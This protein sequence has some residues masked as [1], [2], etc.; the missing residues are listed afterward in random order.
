MMDDLNRDGEIDV[1][2]ATVLYQIVDD[3]Y[4]TP[5]YERF[6]GG[7]GRYEAT[8]AHGPFVHVDARGFRARW[9]K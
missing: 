1:R 2:D 5:I 9:G 7:L 8:A 4:G 3:L 6:V